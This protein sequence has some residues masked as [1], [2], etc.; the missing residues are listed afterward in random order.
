MCVYIYYSYE[1]NLKRIYIYIYPDNFTLTISYNKLVIYKLVI[2]YI[3][4]C[5][6]II[7]RR[8]KR[9]IYKYI[10]YMPI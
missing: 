8:N 1:S 4:Y 9:R 3:H 6:T 2:I 10:T 5:L 7:Y